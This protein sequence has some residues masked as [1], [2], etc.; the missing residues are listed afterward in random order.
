M[1]LA[2]SILALSGSP[3]FVHPGLPQ[4]AAAEVSPVSLTVP[5]G[6]PL[7]LYLT[8]RVSKRID[9]PVEAELMEPVY[10][11]DREVIPAGTVMLG[12]VS[13]T[14]PISKG[15]RFRAILNGDLTPLRLAQV[16]FTTVKLPDGH[17]LAIHTVE[18][19]GLNSI[20]VEPSTKKKKAQN[21]PKPQKTPAQNPNGGILGTAKQ[22]TKDRIQGAISSRTRGLNDIVR[23]PNKKEKLVDFLWSNSAV[24]SPILAPRDAVRR[25]AAGPAGIRLG[26]GRGSRRAGDAAGRR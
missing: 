13:R 8:K 17:E 7:R 1:K 12:K 11:F 23:G 10:A 25:A 21:T 3:F 14:Q 16:E 4:T 24:S 9:A 2:L 20:Y 6:A 26:C 18:N 22:T 19:I 15:Q 5:S